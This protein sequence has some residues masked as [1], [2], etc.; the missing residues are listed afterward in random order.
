MMRGSNAWK[1]WG[2]IECSRVGA[3]KV[4][5]TKKSCGE[6]S[7]AS[8]RSTHFCKDDDARIERNEQERPRRSDAFVARS[9]SLFSLSR[10]RQH[11]WASRAD[12][13]DVQSHGREAALANERSLRQDHGFL[14]FAAGT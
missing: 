1:Q 4:C 13:N 9:V 3:N 10:L 7:N 2:L 11:R 6:G 14:P 8:T 5:Q 12:H